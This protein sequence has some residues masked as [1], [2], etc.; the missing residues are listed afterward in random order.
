M[1]YLEKYNTWL[2][3]KIIDEK[4]KE[5]LRNISEEKELEDRFYKDL[6]F[7]TGGLRGI[8]GAGS[9]RMNV[10][11]VGKATQGLAEYLL[12]KYYDEDIS[13]SIA[14]DSRNMSK[15]FAEFAALTLCANGI[16]V[17]LFESLRPTP[18]LSY[19]VR[20][21]KSKAGIVI[22]ASHNPK[23]YN[24]YKVYGEDGGQV[25]DDTA[26]EILSFINNIDD[27]SKIKFID[28]DEAKKSGL[29]RIIGEEV[30]NAYIDKVK[31]LSIRKDLVKEKAK[32]LK[33]IYTPL[34]GTGNIP[35]RR[36]L[37]ELGYENVHVVKE[38]EMPDGNFPTAEYPN[39]EESKVFNLAL[40]MAEEIEPD[41]IFGTDPDCD[42]IGA[43]VKDN[44]GEYKVLTGNMMGAL[45]T[46][47][48]LSSLKEKGS[49]PKN[50]VVIKTIVTTDMTAEIAKSF[51]VEVIDVLTGFKYIGE[52]IKEFEKTGEKSYI[53]GF[54]ESYGYL[55]GT[56]VRD[57]DAVIASMLICEMALYYKQKGMSLY[58][59]LM[60]LYD[61]YG[62]FKE[63]LVS[64]K[65]EG[66]DGQEKIWKI[67]EHLRHSMKS[68]L[69]GTKIVRKLDYKKRIEKNLITL[70]EYV[71]DLPE[72]NVLKF[73]LEDDSS[74]VVRPSGTEPKM[75]IYLSVKGN[76]ITDAKIKMNTLKES[77]MEIINNSCNQ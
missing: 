34:H 71:I 46:E 9:N 58:D 50:G 30:D 1:D 6:E 38:Q 72:S 8:I 20:Y 31:N 3:S 5:E 76:S 57:K 42:R 66:K 61:K 53:F 11:T 60:N 67:L 44:R 48:I 17:N 14:Y 35:V 55:A 64:I 22:T 65:L 56:F 10:Y 40:K 7:G 69:N 54:E 27:F 41:I 4:T 16:K 45:L 51:N 19:T 33:I 29:L 70:A 28:M 77:V 32:E 43:V 25:T 39:P 59:G 74:F 15:E 62:F 37:K 13:V 49:L 23:E 52:K 68:D 47:Y 24:G 73:I 2:N 12:N 63:E 18:I 26:K 75:K 36:V 21:L